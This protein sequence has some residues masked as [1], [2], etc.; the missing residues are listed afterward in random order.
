MI[1]ILDTSVIL[2]TLLSRGPNA[3]Q[4]ILKRATKKE[5][6]L[7]TCKE[8][9]IDLRSALNN[10]HLKTLP[11]YKP[12][13][14]ARFI[15]WYKYNGQFYTLKDS[16]PDIQLRD[17][18]DAFWFHLISESGAEALITLDKDLLETSKYRNAR[19]LKPDAFL[20]L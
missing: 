3:G 20:K 1:V 19:I 15:A 5:Y 10:H 16:E 11:T 18:T 17:K 6:T 14:L 12:Q 8:A 13:K 9:F 4:E 7:A 2:A